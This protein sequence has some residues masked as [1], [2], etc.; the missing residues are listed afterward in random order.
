LKNGNAISTLNA[1]IPTT[2]EFTMPSTMTKAAQPSPAYPLQKALNALL[3]L[4]VMVVY[5]WSQGVSAAN[6]P[7]FTELVEDNSDAVV[8]ISTTSTPKNGNAAFHG[9][10]LNKRQLEQLPEFFSGFL[11]WPAITVWWCARTRSAAPVH[12]VGIY[13][14]F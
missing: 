7:D 6:L 4:S 11:P 8:N 3:M 5:L 14:V 12:G 13:C 10:P 9:S 2:G 1:L